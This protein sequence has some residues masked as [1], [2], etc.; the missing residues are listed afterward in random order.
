MLSTRTFLLALCLLAAS[1][2]TGAAKAATVTWGPTGFTN[3]SGSSSSD[4]DS[5]VLSFTGFT[6]N[7][8]T[9]ITG[10]GYLHDHSQ[11]RTFTMDVLLDGT[12]TNI[13]SFGPS[14]GTSGNIALSSLS[15]PITFATGIVSGLRL[16]VDQYV[17]WAFHSMNNTTFTFESSAAATGEVPLPAG[18]PL[19]A[20]ALGLGA[21][22]G[23]WRRRRK[24]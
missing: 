3:T 12:W 17:G 5:G 23:A 22:L 13:F 7:S 20:S 18:L 16:T 11:N 8:L 2:A 24:G 15:L 14:G 1:F 10:Y 21:G 9:S 19:L 6:A 4:F